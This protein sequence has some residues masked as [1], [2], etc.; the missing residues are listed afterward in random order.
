MDQNKY[1]KSVH[2]YDCIGPCYDKGIDIIHPVTFR[3]HVNTDKKVCAVKE[4]SNLDTK[5]IFYFDECLVVDTIVKDNVNQLL[6]LIEIDFNMFLRIYYEIY[7]LDDG[8]LY[9]NKNPQLSLLTR[10]RIIVCLMNLFQFDIFDD[11]IIRFFIDYFEKYIDEFITDLKLI[12]KTD[13]D[14]AYIR[15]KFFNKPTILKF[16]V[17][18][19]E[20]KPKT[21][22]NYYL[23]DDL[24]NDYKIYLNK[25]IKKEIK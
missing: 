14:K 23:V 7:S 9:L 21:N 22:T 10:K 16:L 15:N 19:M 17:K 24:K 18:A 4:G 25:K 11:V 6:P 2:G 5:R 13:D 1:Q 3:R 8:I 12:K 20:K